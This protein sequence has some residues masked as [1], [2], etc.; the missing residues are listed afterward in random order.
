MGRL[1]VS[2]V[3]DRAAPLFDPTKPKPSDI[4]GITPAFEQKPDPAQEEGQGETGQDQGAAE[5]AS[6]GAVLSGIAQHIEALG[7]QPILQEIIFQ[8]VQGEMRFDLRRALMRIMGRRVAVQEGRTGAQL[9]ARNITKQIDAHCEAE[10]Y[11]LTLDEREFII[12]SLADG[13]ARELALAADAIHRYAK[14]AMAVNRAKAAR[15]T[16]LLAQMRADRTR[17]SEEFKTR[18][19]NVCR[20]VTG[21]PLTQ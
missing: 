19:V 9:Y 18:L 3:E 14:V 13:A 2:N 8:A 4:L 5:I 15:N 12:Q 7:P 17:L 10:A 1:I 16:P 6:L 21:D 20:A 11:G